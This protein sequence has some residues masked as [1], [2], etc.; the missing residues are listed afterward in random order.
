MNL[1][2]QAPVSATGTSDVARPCATRLKVGETIMLAL[3]AWHVPS[4]QN[5]S[6]RDGDPERAEEISK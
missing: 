1:K 3:L 2:E 5:R 6:L 4:P